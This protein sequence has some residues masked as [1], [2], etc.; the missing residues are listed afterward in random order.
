M[1]NTNLKIATY[2]L[3]GMWQ[4]LPFCRFS[5]ILVISFLFKNTG[6]LHLI[7][8]C[9]TRHYLDIF[10]MPHLPWVTQCPIRSALW[11][12]GHLCLHS[13]LNKMAACSNETGWAKEETRMSDVTVFLTLH[14]ARN[15]RITRCETRPVRPSG[16]RQASPLL[17]G[18]VPATATASRRAPLAP[19]LL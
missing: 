15:T 5:V 11:S 3:H 18:F 13:L 6:W 9:W 2:N 17:A 12:G 10:A 19:L 16:R 8:K 7:L 4:G 1:A 14:V